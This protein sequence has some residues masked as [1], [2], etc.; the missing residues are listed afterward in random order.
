M[1]ERW[2]HKQPKTY[3][4]IKSSGKY[5]IVINQGGARSGKTYSIVQCVIEFCKLNINKGLVISI[6]R[7]TLPALKASVYRDFKEILEKENLYD[8]LN[9]NKS[10]M[11]Y[12]LF[13]NLIEFFA[14][15]QPQKVRGRKRHICF[16]NEANELSYEEF[17]QLNIRTTYKVIID[18]NPSDEFSWI[19]DLEKRNDAVLHVTNY[20]HNPHLDN[21][22]IKE[23]ELLEQSDPDYWNVFGLGLRGKARNLIYTH[24][25][26]CDE[27]PNIGDIVYG[28]DFGYNSPSATIK[29]EFLE[30]DVYWDEV[31]Y[32]RKLIT[33]DLAELYLDKGI[34][35]DTPIYCDSQ[36]ADSIEELKRF[37]FNAQKA[38]KDVNEGIRKVKSKPL[39]V[40]KRSVNLIKELQNYK[41]VMDMATNKP[42]D[43][44]LKFND[45]GV[46][47]GRY[48]TYT[49]SALPRRMKSYST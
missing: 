3:Y 36:A 14:V 21:S 9:H 35:Y 34:D 20:T 8:E 39:Y 10:D 29:I 27:M 11:T 25:Q 31:I 49:H 4:D 32:A 33:A 22:L 23:I 41:F 46:D 18:F 26:L 7:K 12:Y 17:F 43:Q 48:G 47:A 13:G 28:Q 1:I 24:W 37:G 40:T 6:V 5:R 15:D 38:N 45:H 16:I 44:P 30:N 42:T 19:Y 2:P